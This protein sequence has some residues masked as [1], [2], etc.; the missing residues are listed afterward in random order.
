M[1]KGLSPLDAVFVFELI[2]TCL[3]LDCPDLSLFLDEFWNL[4]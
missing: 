4:D 2:C 1:D 3:V